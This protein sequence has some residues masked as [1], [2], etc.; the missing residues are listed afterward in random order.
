MANPLYR[1]GL[2]SEKLELWQKM[3]REF[4]ALPLEGI[5][6]DTGTVYGEQYITCEPIGG[7]WMAMEDWC[8][9][10]FGPTAIEGVWEPGERWYMNS[11]MFW[12]KNPEDAMMFIMRWN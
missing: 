1:R 2:G 12:F 10:T 6:Q 7:D 4:F 3:Y 8:T 11:R 9:E 5:T